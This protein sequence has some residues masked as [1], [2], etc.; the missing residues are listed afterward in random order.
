MLPSQRGCGEQ[1][2]FLSAQV[3]RWWLVTAC[4]ASLVSHGSLKNRKRWEKKYLRA[5]AEASER[6]GNVLRDGKH[7]ARSCKDSLSA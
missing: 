5:T 1:S 6:Q 7:G 2:L 4:R 3:A